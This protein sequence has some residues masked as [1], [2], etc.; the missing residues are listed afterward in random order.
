LCPC[1]A[2]GGLIVVAIA[3]FAVRWRVLLP[4]SPSVPVR[5]VFCYLMIGYMTNAVIPLRLGD[6][7]RAYLLGRR[8][9]ISAIDAGNAPLD[10][11]LFA[12][13]FGEPQLTPLAAAIAVT[14]ADA[15]NR[16]SMARAGAHRGP[17]M[18]N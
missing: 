10:C 7:V 17:E 9:G 18:M 13:Y 11:T 5:Y 1:L 6:L 15:G 8:H 3:I 14:V 16:L 12:K 4:T 2:G